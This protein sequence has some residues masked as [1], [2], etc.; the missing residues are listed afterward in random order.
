MNNVIQRGC[1]AE[2]LIAAE[3][4]KHGIVVSKPLSHSSPYDFIFDNGKNVL[5]VQCK[6]AYKM[7]GWNNKI[8]SLCV[9]SRRRYGFK[10][11]GIKM[12]GKPYRY[13][14]FDVLVACEPLKNRFWILPFSF[15]K[16][17]KSGIYLDTKKSNIY[18]NNWKMI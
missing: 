4:I 13:N 15:C 5:K 14:D 1:E 9:E 7:K 3:A 11:N 18:L 2:L 16:N 17:F 6:R 10:K 8:D 12:Q